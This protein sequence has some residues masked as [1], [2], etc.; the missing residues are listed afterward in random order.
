[1]NKTI[2]LTAT[3]LI[4]LLAAFGQDKIKPILSAQNFEN[5]TAIW[6]QIGMGIINFQAD[7]MYIY[8][9]IYVTPTMPD[10]E[11]HQL[12]T[13]SDAYLFPLFS[14]YKKNQGEL[15]S[16]T[17]NECFLIVNFPNKATKEYN[18]LINELRP[19]KDMIAC[20][21]GN[22][23]QP[24]KLRVLIKDKTFF[25]SLGEDRNCC[26]SLV[27]TLNDLDADPNDIPIVETTMSEITN[28]KG[29]GNVP[30][31]DFMKLKD[32]VSKVHAK[33]K[34]IIVNEVPALKSAW[35][36]LLTSGVDFIQTEEPTKLAEYLT[37]RTDRP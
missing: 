28:W 16:G 7:A 25:Q 2:S 1:M 24:G 33:G 11:N 34:K 4:I 32:L 6:T 37:T 14:L 12:P 13:L 17:P 36:A 27:G 29:S 31:E 18:Q 9:K 19:Y 30:F 26:F 22:K 8:G 21:N 3:F 23:V 20:R 35:E 15:V 10:S 5:K